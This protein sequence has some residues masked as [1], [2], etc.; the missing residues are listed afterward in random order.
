[1][2]LVTGAI[3]MRQCVMELLTEPLDTDRV[4]AE[5]ESEAGFKQHW[6]QYHK[7][8]MDAGLPEERAVPMELQTLRFGDS[9]AVVALAAE[10][11]VE[12]ALRMKRDLRSRFGNVLPLAYANDVI[13]YVP[14]KRQLDRWGYEVL[15][16]NQR[17]NRTGRFVAE[18]EDLVHEK[19]AATLEKVDIL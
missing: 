6:A 17:R 15:Y 9:L 5:L 4:A 19:V 3:D 12:H 11:V 1:M 8:R 13:G 14:V 2:Q 18:T 16:A 7:Q 10:A